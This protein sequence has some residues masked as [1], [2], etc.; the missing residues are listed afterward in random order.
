MSTFLKILAAVGAIA[1]L[2]VAT[3]AGVGAYAAKD[4]KGMVKEVE[5]FA[6]E[7]D[8]YGCEAAAFDKAETCNGTIC[9]VKVAAWHGLCLA[10]ATPNT[11]Y[12]DGVPH[13]DDTA[14]SEGWYASTCAKVEMPNDEHCHIVLGAT[15]GMCH[16]A[17]F[18]MEA[19]GVPVTLNN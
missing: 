17:D 10:E 8:Q 12:C 3:C 18:K 13:P 1:F 7:N 15:Q 9:L 6:A 2:L 16:S 4:M 5:A 19:N 11:G 14:A